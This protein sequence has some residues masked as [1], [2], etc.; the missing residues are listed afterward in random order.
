MFIVLFLFVFSA[1]GRDVME[2]NLEIQSVA[3]EYGGQLIMT[4]KQDGVACK[5]CNVQLCYEGSHLGLQT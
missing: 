2:L 1:I 4:Q 5:Q 3:W